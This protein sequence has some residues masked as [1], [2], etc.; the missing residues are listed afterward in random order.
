MNEDAQQLIRNDYFPSW[1]WAGWIQGVQYWSQPTF[2]FGSIYCT[3]ND[4]GACEY[5]AKDTRQLKSAIAHFYISGKLVQREIDGTTSKMEKAPL[6]TTMV[7]QEPGRSDERGSRRDVL[8]FDALAVSIAD[9]PSSQLRLLRRY[10]PNTKGN[11]FPK[12]YETL[13]YTD[14][15]VEAFKQESTDL[16]LMSRDWL[17]LLG[18]KNDALLEDSPDHGYFVPNNLDFREWCLLNLMIITWDTE[19]VYAERAGLC[20]V[21]EDIWNQWNPTPKHIYLT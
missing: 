3:V 4:K 9:I 14:D 1:S 13:L 5:A 2:V 18:E 17:P 12:V 11:P 7:S 16:L 20:V 6:I 8:E 10:C 21:H 19:G 15:D